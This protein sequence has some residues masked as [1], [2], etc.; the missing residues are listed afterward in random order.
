MCIINAARKR[1]RL[2]SNIGWRLLFARSLEIVLSDYLL[3]LCSFFSLSVLSACSVCYFVIFT[4]QT[5]ISLACLAFLCLGGEFNIKSTTLWPS[6][7][8]PFTR[9]E[10]GAWKQWMPEDTF[11]ESWNSKTCYFFMP[12][13][14]ILYYSWMEKKC[15]SFCKRMG[16]LRVNL[17]NV[18][19]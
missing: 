6:S 11:M 9:P 12:P 17:P 7:L 16:C 3:L 4:V 18:I 15:F 5:C 13:V 10:M 1:G 14:R 8:R 2:N 19:L